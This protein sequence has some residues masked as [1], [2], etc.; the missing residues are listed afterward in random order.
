MRI[1]CVLQ[2]LRA[3]GAQRVFSLMADVWIAEAHDVSLLL[4]TD[5]SEPDFTPVHPDVDIRRLGILGTTSGGILHKI[6]KNLKRFPVVRKAVSEIRP[7][8]VIGFMI[9]ENLVLRLSTLGMRVPIILV[10]H[11]PYSYD[12]GYLKRML[13]DIVYPLADGVVMLTRQAKA[14]AVGSVRSR[15]VVIENPIRI[16][17]D[18]SSRQLAEK[19]TTG[20][21]VEGVFLAIGRFARQKRFDRLIWAFSKIADTC[22]GWKVHLYGSGDEEESMRTLVAELGLENC[23]FLKGAVKE[24]WSAL[25]EGDVFVMSSDTEGFPMALIEAMACG[26]AVV[27]TDCPTGPGEL[28]V[29]GLNGLLVSVDEEA[30]AA[31]MLRLATDAS[32]RHKLG[33]EATKIK[34]RL[35]CERI[36]TRY[37]GFIAACRSTG[38]ETLRV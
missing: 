22:P 1:L 20:K 17:E 16:P 10:E 37:N 12:P 35:G 34:E 27:S 26:L 11:S 25:A 28:V 9:D 36:M 8:C 13:Q 3:G 6:G 18:L 4:F 21:K 29:D 31:G 30:L 14:H 15:T 32:L 38:K 7:D 19:E 2:T 24:P 23:V 5:D 33:A